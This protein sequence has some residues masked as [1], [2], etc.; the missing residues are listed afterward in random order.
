MLYKINN[1]VFYE[2]FLVFGLFGLL[3]DLLVVVHGFDFYFLFA[4][5]LDGI[6][7]TML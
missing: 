1:Y 5:N 4:C 2:N 3:L 7:S 6:H